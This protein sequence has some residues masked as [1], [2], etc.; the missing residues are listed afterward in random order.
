MS[1]TYVAE[2]TWTAGAA[3]SSRD[4]HSVWTTAELGLD[5]VAVRHGVLLLTS[6]VLRSCRHGDAIRAAAVFRL[7]AFG[8][9][10]RR[11]HRYHHASINQSHS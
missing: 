8:G 3:R 5:A 2:W 7:A 6:G 4:R 9:L 11:L 10:Y 1:G